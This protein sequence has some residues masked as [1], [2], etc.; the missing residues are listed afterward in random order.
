MPEQ[1]GHSELPGWSNQPTVLVVGSIHID[2]MVR[3]STLPVPGETVTGSESWTQLGGKAANQAVAVAAHVRTVLAACVG[4]DHE[5][6]QAEAVLIRRG[7]TPRLQRSLRLPTGSSVALIEASGENIGVIL[8]GSNAE[9]DAGPVA[10]LLSTEGPALLVC[11]WETAV[12][13]LEPLLVEARTRGVPTLMNAAPWQDTH[14]S[15]LAL[16]DH[17]V[18]NAVEAEDWTGT[19]PQA[20]LPRLPLDHPSVVVTLGA[21]GVLHYQHGK[22]TSDLP[23]PVVRAH[24]THGA[25]DHFVGVLAA[26]L[27]LGQRLEPALT[28]AGASAAQYVQIV[29]RPSR[30][31]SSS[32]ELIR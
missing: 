21:G 32:S 16:A 9:L 15:L 30:L 5:G 10:A 28:Q 26:Q 24:S 31:S 12:T 3:L 7:V 14:R 17:V 13:T 4:D 2:R 25:G 20:R 6:H 27:A 29:H 19:D 8:S 18:V 23:A 1:P 22:L 11:Q